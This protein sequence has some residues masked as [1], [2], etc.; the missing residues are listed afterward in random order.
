[1]IIAYMIANRAKRPIRERIPYNPFLPIYWKRK[2][3]V[4]AAAEIGG[5]AQVIRIL[6]QETLLSKSSMRRHM[7]TSA[8]NIHPGWPVR[9]KRSR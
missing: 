3:A 5:T 4:W 9:K 2:D 7:K 1:M 8:I 6:V